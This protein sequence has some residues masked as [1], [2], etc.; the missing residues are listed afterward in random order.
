MTVL[1][2]I[3]IHKAPISDRRLSMAS[4]V[5]AAI[6]GGYALTSLII[7]ALS[8]LLPLFGMAQAGAVH[9]V[10]VISFLIYAVIIMAVFHTRT[11]ARAWLGLAAAALPCGLIIGVAFLVG[12]Q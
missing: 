12:G 2:S 3:L 10:T 8:Y 5:L 7:L 11:A 4:R 6:A 9:A 1:R